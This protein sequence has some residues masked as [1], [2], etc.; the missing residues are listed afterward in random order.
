MID[1]EPKIKT[2]SIWGQPGPFFYK[3]LGD[4]E[5]EGLPA[6]ICILGCGDGRYVIPAAINGFRCTAVD[7]N[8]IHLYGGID[9]NIKLSNKKILGLAGR[10]RLQGDIEDLVEIREEN[11]LESQPQTQYSGVFLQAAIHYEINS[12]YPLEHIL[13]RI[14]MYVINGGFLYLEYIHRSE[15]NNSQDG[16]YITSEDLASFYGQGWIVLKNEV[17]RS[18][19]V[20]NLLWGTFYAKKL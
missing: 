7:I 17:Q 18:P 15:W 19:N 20:H 10:V 2:E 9:E 13:S 8:S 11:F 6:N 4:I 1:R 12:A 16:K 14:G 5:S 3:F